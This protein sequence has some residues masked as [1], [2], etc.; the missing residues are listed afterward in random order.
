MGA[1]M[2]AFLGQIIAVGFNFAPQ[3][4]ALCDGSLL[5]ISQHAALYNLLG[6]TYGGDGVSSFALPDLRGRL[7]LCQ[8]QGPGL[9]DYTLGMTGG[10][11]NVTLR[12]SQI[13]A[14]NHTLM[15]YQWGATDPVPKDKLTAD[16]GA[17][18]VLTTNIQAAVNMY[19]PGPP[20]VTLSPAALTTTSGPGIPHENRQP[21]L[22]INY[23]ICVD[24]IYP[25]QG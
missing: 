7:A 22:A 23:I 12:S 1:F 3:G 9:S 18:V 21:Y 5:Q 25:S 14:H 10:A 13:G 6:T 17:T 11:E 8:G 16:P 2:D 19:N 4:W 24:G 20:N 15:A